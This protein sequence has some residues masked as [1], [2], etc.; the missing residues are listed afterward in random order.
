MDLEYFND[1]VTT[2]ECGS[3]HK[4]ADRLHLRQQNLS[5]IIKKVE[6]YYDITIFDRS[7]KG[8][9][10]T[11]DGEY[12]LERA[13]KILALAEELEESYKYPSKKHY[14]NV[15]DDI[16]LFVPDILSTGRWLN[17][18]QKF[19]QIFPYINLHILTRSLNDALEAIK[20]NEKALI[21]TTLP[22]Y[23]SSF[24][25]ALPDDLTMHQLPVTVYFTAVTGPNNPE[26]EKYESIS[27]AELLQK[28]LVIRSSTTAEDSIFFQ[29]L[30]Y[31]GEPTVQYVIDNTSLFIDFL[32]NGDYWSLAQKSTNRYDLTH[33][34]LKE[35]LYA[36]VHLIYHKSAAASFPFQT[37]IKQLSE[38]I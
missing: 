6:R 29:L 7:S 23:E 17:G 36:T 31:Y 33:I 4:A 37:L 30:Q 10:L 8:V 14:T 2:S 38:N 16:T 26:A 32:S 1:I 19:N 13:R 28:K 5:S 20:H 25:D 21:S 34:P 27:V 9:T 22:F 18:I 11:R 15:V 3:I 35:N 24:A 12:F